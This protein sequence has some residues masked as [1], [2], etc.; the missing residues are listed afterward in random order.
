VDEFVNRGVGKAMEK[1]KA[2][3]EAIWI[4]TR[5]LRDCEIESVKKML[6]LVDKLAKDKCVEE[7]SIGM[8]GWEF[9]PEPIGYE[10]FREIFENFASNLVSMKGSPLKRV[11]IDVSSWYT[12]HLEAYN[13]LAK[14]MTQ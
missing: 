8:S 14:S 7:I 1:G 2:R 5:L 11:K 6:G 4:H 9:I 12:H 3:F 13:F 10:K